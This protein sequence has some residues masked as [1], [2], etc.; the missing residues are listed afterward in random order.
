MQQILFINMRIKLG[1]MLFVAQQ[2][3]VCSVVEL[4][5]Q[6]EVFSKHFGTVENL[7]L[8]TPRPEEMHV[9]EA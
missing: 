3:R 5:E 6:H 8:G 4:F 1:A 9:T 2:R 7:R